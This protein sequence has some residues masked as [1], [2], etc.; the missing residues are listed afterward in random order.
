MKERGEKMMR[1]KRNIK[2]EGERRKK[3]EGKKERKRN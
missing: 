2:D 3:D 1:E